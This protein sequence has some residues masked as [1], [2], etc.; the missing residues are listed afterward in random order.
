MDYVLT[1]SRGVVTE[2]DGLV[3]EQFL[4]PQTV[5]F[6]TNWFTC[7][8]LE[9]DEGPNRIA[10]RYTDD[11]GNVT[12]TNFTF[13]VDLVGDKHAPVITLIWPTNNAVVI[14]DKVTIRGKLDD[15]SGAIEG[16][17]R[18]GERR[19]R[20]EGE[21]G[22]WGDFGIEELPLFGVTN[23]VTLKATDAAGNIAITNFMVRRS[24]VFLTFDSPDPAAIRSRNPSISGTINVTNHTVFINGTRATMNR[25][26]KWIAT[27]VTIPSEG[28]MFEA[29]VIPNE[30]LTNATSVVPTPKQPAL[31]KPYIH[32]LSRSKV[33][34]DSRPRSLRV[35]AEGAIYYV[36]PRWAYSSLSARTSRELFRLK[37]GQ[38]AFATFSEKYYQKL[39]RNLGP[40]T[41][42]DH[43]HL[44]AAQGWL[45]LGNWLE[46]NAELENITP[47]QRAH[48]DVLRLRV[49]I[50][51]AADK[52][53]YVVGGGGH[54]FS[55]DSRR[56]LRAHPAG[57]RAP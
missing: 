13:V 39:S 31:S 29:T 25:H 34:I 19:D 23:W 43:H 55:H 33:G 27:N 24:D 42:R 49:E 36:M 53:D 45:E 40:V 32:G 51:S 6:T 41:P 52:W 8:D 1:T 7:Y 10:M 57:V 22:R 30:Q 35:E 56:F 4:D 15:P 50:Y 5:Q 48:P 3:N 9:L 21:I 12:R 26:N 46:A 38:V 54:S 11:A 18:S 28:P 20:R 14:G 16:E 2:G 17:I 37:R 47:Q 44:R